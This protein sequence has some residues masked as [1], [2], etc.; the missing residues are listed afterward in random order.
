MVKVRIVTPDNH[1]TGRHP[2]EGRCPSGYRRIK[3]VPIR[4]IAGAQMPLATSAPTAGPGTD[5]GS[6]SSP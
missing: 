6:T 3:N 1:A 2:G 4:P 5:P